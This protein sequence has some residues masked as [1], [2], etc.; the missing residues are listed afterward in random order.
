MAGS[1]LL[2]SVLVAL[3]EAG[4]L[5]CKFCN[6]PVP[7]QKTVC[8]ASGCV[9][10]RNAEIARNY[11]QANRDH[12]NA[13]RR[14]RYHSQQKVLLTVPQGRAIRALWREG[15]LI[16]KGCVIYSPA[17]MQRVCQASV[18]Q[19]LSDKGLA[20]FSGGEWKPL[21]REGEFLSR[22]YQI[23][24][25][26]KPKYIRTLNPAQARLLRSIYSAPRVVVLGSVVAAVDQQGTTNHIGQIRTALNLAHIGII[27]VSSAG[28]ITVLMDEQAVV[29][30]FK[31]YAPNE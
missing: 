24:E 25:K 29:S 23:S 1:S 16:Q 14:S 12:I 22:G 27:Q 19:C 10:Q 8:N 4:N 5:K 17:T 3:M 9:L 18:I 7:P 26:P 30:S 2:E 31:G 21:I 6:G 20:S 11:L 15:A 13:Q 28:V